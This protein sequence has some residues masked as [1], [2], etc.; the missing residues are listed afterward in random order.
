M[1][2]RR[3]LLPFCVALG[4]AVLTG[5]GISHDTISFDPV[6]KAATKTAES[7]SARVAF[8]A[9]VNIEG[10]GA[11]SF[12]GTGVFDGRTKSA[13][14]DMNFNLPPAAQAQFGGNSTMQLILDGRHGFIMYMRSPLFRTMVPPETWVKMDLRKLADKAGVD[15]GGLMSSNQADPTQQL[16]MLMASTDSKVLN[17]D[18]VRGALTTHY[19]FRID[20]ERL[21][22]DNKDLRKS[23]DAVKKITGE[24]SFPAEAWIDS[25]GRVR[26][27][28]VDMSM[29]S[30]LG[31]GMTMTMTEDLYDFGV[32]ANIQAPSGH[33]VD[34]S[35]LTGH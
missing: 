9:S 3:L 17:Y 32:N 31:A 20:L 15:L 27:M 34:I 19:A 23:L 18:R 30:Q 12:S 26:R 25:Q 7:T 16:R 35:S 14:L 22:K 10:V 11:M 5:C 21:A 29:G 24:T 8:Q 4:A 33:V 6:A 1:G 13:A 2:P 28:K